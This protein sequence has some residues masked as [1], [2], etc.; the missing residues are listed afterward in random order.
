MKSGQLLSQLGSSDRPKLASIWTRP[1][2]SWTIFLF[3]FFSWNGP[4]WIICLFNLASLWSTQLSFNILGFLFLFWKGPGPGSSACLDGFQCTTNILS[5]FPFDFFFSL[6]IISFLLLECVSANIIWTIKIGPHW[7]NLCGT[8]SYVF[9]LI[10]FLTSHFCLIVSQ[11]RSFARLNWLPFGPPIYP[12][13]ILLTFC[14]FLCNIQNRFP[15]MDHQYLG[16]VS[17]WLSVYLT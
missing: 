4:F 17:L 3:M 8:F 6:Y 9:F 5:H 7:T 11:L 10:H 15:I 1:P 16:Q 13:I 2:I 12:T 14:V